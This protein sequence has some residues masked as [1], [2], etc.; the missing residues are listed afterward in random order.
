MKGW[1]KSQASQACAHQVVSDFGLLMVLLNL[2]RNCKMDNS[3]NYK[4][5]DAKVSTHGV[6]DKLPD[7]THPVFLS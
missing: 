3:E 2:Y 6:V 4:V 5:V 1:A 7:V